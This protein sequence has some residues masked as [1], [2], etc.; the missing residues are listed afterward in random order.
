[1]SNF[2]YY[3][4]RLSIPKALHTLFKLAAHIFDMYTDYYY[5]TGTPF[6]YPGLKTA[7]MI[8]FMLPF[9]MTFF[10]AFAKAVDTMA[11]KKKKEAI[12]DLDGDEERFGFV[13][14]IKVYILTIINHD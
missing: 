11:K 8:I 5:L 10:I 13:V 1:M 6:V 2:A 3:Y 14:F 9:V 12:G 4:T 7:C